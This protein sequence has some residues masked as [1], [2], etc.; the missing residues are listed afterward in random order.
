MPEIE[1]NKELAVKVLEDLQTG[2]IFGYNQKELEKF[3]EIYAKKRYESYSGKDYIGYA[4][5]HKRSTFRLIFP[6]MIYMKRKYPFLIKYPFLVFFAW[7]HRIF[8]VLIKILLGK[9]N[10]SDYDINKPAV[11][12]EKIIDRMKLMEELGLI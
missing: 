5:K 10:V 4:K 2:G 6:S 12:N 9:R 3:K 1:I 11:E 8:K 7:I